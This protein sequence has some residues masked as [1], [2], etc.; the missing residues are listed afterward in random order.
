M[1]EIFV[2]IDEVSGEE[3]KLLKIVHLVTS[4]TGGAGLAAVRLHE[5]LLQAH[6]DS[7][8]ITV[9]RRSGVI[10]K[11]EIV[12][13]INVTKRLASSTLTFF[14]K[15]LVQ[16]GE[17]LVTT[18][19]LDL[20][21]WNDSLISTADVL[22]LHSFYNLVSIQNFL[23][24]YPEKAK[25]VT[26]HDERFY[27]GGC[28]VSK[29]CSQFSFGCQNCPQVQRLFQILV[30][31]VQR[32]TKLLLE[33]DVNLMFVCPSNW[34]KKR[35]MLAF[36]M[37]EPRRFI[38]I[39]NPIP[40]M[41][42]SE[43]FEEQNQNF[44]KIGFISQEL[45][46]PIKNLKLLLSAFDKINKTYPNKYL[47]Y[48]VGNSRVDYA[49]SSSNIIQKKANNLKE[50]QKILCEIDLLVVPSSFDNLPNVLGE[51]LMNG[52]GLVG[53]NVGGIP[54][55]L[56][57]FEQPIFENGDEVSLIKALSSFEL[58][59]REALKARAQSIFGYEA[60]SSRI[61]KAYSSQLGNVI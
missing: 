53:S 10:T 54:E 31:H 35:A 32:K 44:I 26:L 49:S 18:L 20:I 30:S 33:K 1:R 36:P 21:D 17:D 28:H 24:Y 47:L 40:N 52:V 3:G 41:N 48:L 9:S 6:Q 29:N 13:D 34:I 42:I 55:V 15:T 22:H 56:N 39:Y 11:S 14:Q 8:L 4:I 16:K 59:D 7:H 51:A 5:S 58:I 12:Q 37:L 23:E 46:N 25:F 38:E 50:L 60:V 57:L 2:L 19:S 27:T 61:I 45:A 43:S